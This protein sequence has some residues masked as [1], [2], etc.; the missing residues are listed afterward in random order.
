MVFP[1]KISSFI[2]GDY[3]YF[4]SSG[5]DSLDNLSFTN[6]VFGFCQ[7]TLKTIEFA[8]VSKQYFILERSIFVYI[9]NSEFQS[10]FFLIS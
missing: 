8:F 3:Y 5:L 1:I 4:T 7:I 9:T 10:F 6:S 2:P